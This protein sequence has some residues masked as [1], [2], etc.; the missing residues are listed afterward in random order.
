MKALVPFSF[1]NMVFLPEHENN[2]LIIEHEIAHI[3]Q[4]HWFD[5][6]IA[7]IATV[8]LWFNPFVVLYKNSLKLQHEYLADASVLKDSRKTEGYLRCMLQRVQLVSSGGL[9]SHF[10]CKTIKKRIIMISKNKNIG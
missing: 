2:P 6:I 8:L 9:T 10:Y 4:L 5:L 1:F 3:R 7:E